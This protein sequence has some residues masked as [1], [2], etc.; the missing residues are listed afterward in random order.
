MQILIVTSGTVELI[1]GHGHSRTVCGAVIPARA[2][3]VVRSYDARGTLVYCEAD[4]LLGRAAQS[5]RA[6]SDRVS[7]W[8][9]AA[10]QSEGPGE[11]ADRLGDSLLELIGEHAAGVGHPAV[12]AAIAHIRLLLGGPVHLEDVAAVAG[13]SPSRLG[14]LFAQEVGMSFP[15]YVRWAR[16]R[17]AIEL[18]R[19]GATLTQAAYG[20]GFCDSSHLTRVVHEMFGLAPS[21]LLRG[22]RWQDS[23]TATTS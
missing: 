12:R 7:D 3:H 8:V 6:L 22:V 13:I 23:T 16:L 21:E 5:H 14:H 10:E 18:V 11:G 20:A 9:R 1:D 19:A 15:T 2:V 4:S 17:R